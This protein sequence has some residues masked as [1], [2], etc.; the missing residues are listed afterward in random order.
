MTRVILAPNDLLTSFDPRAR[1][2]RYGTLVVKRILEKNKPKDYFQTFLKSEKIKSFPAV[3]F[4]LQN[5]LH[6]IPDFLLEFFDK[7]DVQ[8]QEKL[9]R[10]F[11][12]FLLKTDFK[13]LGDQPINIYLRLHK[14]EVRALVQIPELPLL[15]HLS[16]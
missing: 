3:V 14:S 9:L 7:S 6:S 11:H 16:E 13:F 5:Q 4:E 15:E 12:Q 8:F 10:H 2:Y 1:T